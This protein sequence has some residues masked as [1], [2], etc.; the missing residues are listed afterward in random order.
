MLETSFSGSWLPGYSWVKLLTTLPHTIL[1]QPSILEACGAPSRDESRFSEFFSD[2]MASDTFR[3]SLCSFF[4]ITDDDDDDDDDGS[5]APP[6]DAAP[7]A[8]AGDPS[9][10]SWVRIRTCSTMS[11]SVLARL[12]QHSRAAAIGLGSGRDPES[13]KSRMRASQEHPPSLQILLHSPSSGEQK[14]ALLPACIIKRI[15]FPFW[16]PDSH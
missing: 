16:V 5:L 8:P 10:R 11:S 14:V 13:E 4:C 12:D 1:R 9:D 7:A 2:A 3:L 15:I 6:D